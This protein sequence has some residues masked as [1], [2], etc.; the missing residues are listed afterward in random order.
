MAWRYEKKFY[1][2]WQDYRVLREALLSFMEP[3]PHTDAQRRYEVRSLYFDTIDN[4][5]F[6]EK[7]EGIEKRRKVRLRCYGNNEDPVK[8]EVKEKQ[9]ELIRKLSSN[10]KRK[11]AE[12][13]AATP[14]HCALLQHYA[15]AAA[16]K[17]QYLFSTRLYKPA[18][19]ITY[20]REAYLLKENGVRVTFD[21][22][23]RYD[24]TSLALFPRRTLMGSCA[25]P[26]VVIAEVKYYEF[27]P[28]FI[29]SLL[30]ACSLQRAAISK[31]CMGRAGR[32]LLSF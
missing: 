30:Q 18:A 4:R 15:G 6:H 8:L 21:L 27:L 14:D 5:D 23:L 9:G 29:W 26:G 28:D 32:Q 2:S 7:M 1:L 22:D 3:D 25:V 11:D 31:Y 19:L 17:V 24:T 10:I 20:F 12:R 16:R 13:L